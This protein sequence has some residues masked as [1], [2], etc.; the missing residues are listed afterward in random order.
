MSVRTIKNK[1]IRRITLI[2]LILC[3]PLLIILLFTIAFFKVLVEVMKELPGDIRNA[4]K[5]SM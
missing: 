2:F 5:D 1:Y 4:W 3:S